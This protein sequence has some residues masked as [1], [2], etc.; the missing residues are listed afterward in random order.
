MKQSLHTLR[1]A[2]FPQNVYFIFVFGSYEKA[3]LLR[4][5]LFILLMGYKKGVMIQGDKRVRMR[6]S[7]VA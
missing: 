1:P 5:T 4:N 7:G 3:I 2:P 6:Q